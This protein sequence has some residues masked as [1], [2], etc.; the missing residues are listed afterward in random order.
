M[1][2]SL[3]G[4]HAVWRLTT[5]GALTWCAVVAVLTALLLFAL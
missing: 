5:A 3:K 1:L 4:E 2:G